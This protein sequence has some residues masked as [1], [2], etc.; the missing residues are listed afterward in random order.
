MAQAIVLQMRIPAVSHYYT[1]TTAET[2]TIQ[3]LTALVSISMKNFNS[4]IFNSKKQLVKIQIA[5]SKS[6]AAAAQIDGPDNQALDLKKLDQSFRFSGWL[7]DET[8]QTAWNKFWKIV[9]MQTVGGPLI[10]LNFGSPITLAFPT[11]NYNP[12]FK[13][14]TPQAF[15][16]NI[17]GEVIADDTGDIMTIHPAKPARIR[18]DLDIYLGFSR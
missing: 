1:L 10:A 14:S 13:T 18:V 5:K 8:D 2:A 12:T 17:T 6:S 9:A 11:A 4:M 15:V 16:E 3:G 7:E